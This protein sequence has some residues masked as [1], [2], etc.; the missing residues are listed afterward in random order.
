MTCSL[1]SEDV[2]EVMSV[3]E[4][5]TGA[6]ADGYKEQFMSVAFQQS[7][8]ALTV[9]EV[10]IGCCFVSEEGDVVATGRNEVNLTKNAT[11]H[12]EMVAID[13]VIASNNQHLFER[14]SLYVNV[15]PCIMCAAAL[16]TLRIS[17]IY[18]GCRN[19]K[20]GGCGSVVDLRKIRGKFEPESRYKVRISGGH[21]AAEAV[22]MLKTF[23]D[24]QNPN[25]PNP[26]VKGVRVNK[27]ISFADNQP[28]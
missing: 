7:E 23:Y 25:A 4:E 8:E 16:A 12:A 27:M 10:P 19:E 20:F 11:R 2:T 22:E 6:A 3:S 17:Q 9:G 28:G 1:L 15:E 5:V 14:M 26:K 21:R 18:Y 13:A 24:G